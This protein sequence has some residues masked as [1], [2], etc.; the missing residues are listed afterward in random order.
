M[1]RWTVGSVGWGPPL[2]E[3]LFD[4]VYAPDLST[5]THSAEIGDLTYEA[6]DYLFNLLMTYGNATFLGSGDEPEWTPQ[7]AILAP[8]APR[9]A[10]AWDR[11]ASNDSDDFQAYTWVGPGVDAVSLTIAAHESGLGLWAQDWFDGPVSDF[12][13][14]S[15]DI[16][17]AIVV[18]TWSDD[19]TT[20]AGGVLLHR[21]VASDVP[22]IGVTEIWKIP[23]VASGS[24]S[25]DIDVTA[26]SGDIQWATWIDIYSV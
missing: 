8:S 17:R 12:L 9:R 22:S 23:G 25:V 26:L 20:V 3:L 21:S 16:H 24:S 13:V 15:V 2:D 14:P 5:V 4:F 11:I 19:G 18:F 6:G 10:Y 7:L 1:T